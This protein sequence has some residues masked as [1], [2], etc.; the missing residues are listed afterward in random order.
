MDACSKATDLRLA[1]ISAVWASVNHV[2][3]RDD[4]WDHFEPAAAFV[5]MLRSMGIPCGLKMHQQPYD[6]PRMFTFPLNSYQS[7]LEGEA[8]G[9]D[10]IMNRML[11]CLFV[12]SLQ[13]KLAGCR[14][15]NLILL[16]AH[17]MA[18]RM[19]DS[20]GPDNRELRRIMMDESQR[21]VNWFLDT[22]GCFDLETGSLIDKSKA[23]QASIDRESR[24]AEIRAKRRGNGGAK[25]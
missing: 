5:D 6:F 17:L 19:V 4:L 13:F 25:P 11:F 15:A 9:V 14:D 12:C 18:V 24:Q 16:E 1:E 23:L 20:F 7:E 10:I 3:Y 8:Q 2:V 21:W 22:L